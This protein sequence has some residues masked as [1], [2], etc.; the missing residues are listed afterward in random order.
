MYKI[1]VV[2]AGLSGAVLSHILGRHGDYSIDIFE[3]K[4]HIA[5]NCFTYRDKDTGIL[6][7]KYGPHIFHTK[8]KD[9]WDFVS[10]FVK[11]GPYINR[12]KANTA[13][14]IYSLPINLLTINQ[15]FNLKM[16]PSEALDFIK[17]QSDG[18]IQE[19]K[20]FE[21]QALKFLGRDLYENF[22]RGYTVK[23][24][25][26][27]PTQLPA[28]ILQRLPIR[29]NYDDNYFSDP[30]QGIPLEGYT[31][32]VE[33]LLAGSLIR[34]HLNTSFQ[35][36][37]CRDYDH[38]FYTGTLDG[39]FDYVHGRLGYRSL[40]FERADEIGDFQGNAVMNY[41]EEKVLYTRIAE[42]KHFAPWESH[43]RT[44]IFKEFSKATEADDVPFYPMR[45]E[46]DKQVLR[47]YID[48]AMKERNITF[49]GR[50]G[51]Y[52]YLD[53]DTCIGEALDLAYHFLHRSESD[54][55]T[56]FSRHPI[57]GGPF[58]MRPLDDSNYAEA[59]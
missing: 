1:A 55:F 35:R 2:G 42:H 18:S 41:C 5:G 25:G 43:E 4:D 22:F 45:L 28:S 10:Q 38:V 3:S 36:S 54:D 19:P 11:F 21:E 53:M 26:V 57:D 30:Y 32:L 16:T 50:L 47:G 39:Y 15:F 58:P 51:T 13:K 29:F 40:I 31:E 33:H 23:Q 27:H 17:R 49:V 24:W 46:A 7:H 37:M 34:V 48:L 6:I 9:V 56:A 59:A 52:R 8:R 12:V 20:N 14:G 44:V